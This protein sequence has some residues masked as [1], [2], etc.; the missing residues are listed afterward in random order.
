MYK[1]GERCGV[2]RGRGKHPPRY[3]VIENL[4]G[5]D[6]VGFLTEIRKEYKTWR[7]V[8]VVLGVDENLL[9]EYRRRI[10][11][12]DRKPGRD[13]IHRGDWMQKFLSA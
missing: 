11:L 5:D 3:K 8:A 2:H 4:V 12:I 9:R 1:Y 10:G 6:P 13:W 7:L